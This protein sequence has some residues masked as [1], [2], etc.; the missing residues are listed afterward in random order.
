MRYCTCIGESSQHY[1][2][3][4]FPKVVLLYYTCMYSVHYKTR[5]TRTVAKAS[6]AQ[7]AHLY[8]STHLYNW[9]T[10][11]IYIME[12]PKSQNVL[13]TV[14]IT[15][16]GRSLLSRSVIFFFHKLIISVI[17]QLNLLR[18]DEEFNKFIEQFMAKFLISENVY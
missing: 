14:Y 4:I 5:T 11:K 17:N 16:S 18:S 3:G 2:Q 9:S 15:R 7:V 13:Y 6:Y 10:Q 8:W 1:Q 12:I